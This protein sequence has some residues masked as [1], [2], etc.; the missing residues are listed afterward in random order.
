MERE[1]TTIRLTIRLPE[2]LERQIRQEAARR[3]MNKNQTM[4]YILNRY[5]KENPT[6]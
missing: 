4:L 2:E 6:R 3:G 5:F 1:Q